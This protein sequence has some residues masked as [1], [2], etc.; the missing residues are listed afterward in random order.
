MS[1]SPGP[2]SGFDEFS[3]AYT[4]N[5]PGKKHHLHHIDRITEPL[6]GCYTDREIAELVPDGEEGGDAGKQE[7]PIV[8]R[9]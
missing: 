1:W 8:A 7:W 9:S 5:S 2:H 6:L 3:T 4:P